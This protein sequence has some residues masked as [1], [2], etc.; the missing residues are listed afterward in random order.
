M[1]SIY[2][3]Y[4]RSTRFSQHE[5]VNSKSIDQF[6]NKCIDNILHGLNNCNWS[7]GWCLYTMLYLIVALLKE[8]FT[9]PAIPLRIL[10]MDFA[11]QASPSFSPL[12]L[13]FKK[14]I[15]VILCVHQQALRGFVAI[16]AFVEAKS[17]ACHVFFIPAFCYRHV[18]LC[19]IAEHQDDFTPVKIVSQYTG[20]WKFVLTDADPVNWN[21]E[22]YFDPVAINSSIVHPGTVILQLF[23]NAKGRRDRFLASSP[24]M[25]FL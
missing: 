4:F 22:E 25:W 15:L 21:A 10:F 18:K 20:F 6:G 8:R 1:Q 17:T 11:W 3:Q 16:Q 5:Q 24:A 23:T 19:V 2:T 14:E 7:C 12:R 13:V 9:L